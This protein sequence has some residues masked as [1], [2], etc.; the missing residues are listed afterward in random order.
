MSSG[1]T[2]HPPGSCQQEQTRSISW[3]KHGSELPQAK[4]QTN[5]CEWHN[6]GY[7]CWHNAELPCIIF[8]L[9]INNCLYVEQEKSKRYSVLLEM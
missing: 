6:E 4:E 5:K 7:V 9:P 2:C 1:G 3:Y 8:T